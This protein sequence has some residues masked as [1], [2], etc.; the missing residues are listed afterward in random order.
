MHAKQDYR[1]KD[2]LSRIVFQNA[3]L[4]V[5]ATR[6]AC[7]L[8]R[9]YTPIG[10]GRERATFLMRS[11]VIKLPLD[12]GGMAS[13]RREARLCRSNMRRHARARL[14]TVDSV[15]LVMMEHLASVDMLILRDLVGDW[16]GELYEF[17]VGMSRSGAFK[18]FDYGY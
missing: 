12:E 8:F 16:P 15:D 7:R 3:H 5:A 1:R 2:I 10:M 13:N 6:L 11:H 14:V 17:Q 4:H 9:A 18:A